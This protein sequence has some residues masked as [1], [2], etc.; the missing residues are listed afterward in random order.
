VSSGEELLH[1][2][3]QDMLF[4]ENFGCLSQSYE[5][6]E[7]L[8]KVACFIREKFAALIKPKEMYSADS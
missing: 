1:A 7:K 2:H 4:S 3:K 8:K 5:G 6:R